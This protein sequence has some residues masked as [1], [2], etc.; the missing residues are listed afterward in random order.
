M[1]R[2]G[3]DPSQPG[4]ILQ[5][6]AGVT[7]PLTAGTAFNRLV[8]AR[9]RILTQLAARLQRAGYAPGPIRDVAHGYRM[10]IVTDPEGHRLELV[11]SGQPPAGVVTM[12][13]A[14][15]R[16]IAMASLLPLAAVASRAAGA[17][18]RPA[19]PRPVVPATTPLNRLLHRLRPQAATILPRSRSARSRGARSLAYTEPAN[20]PA[21]HCGGCA[22]FV[23]RRQARRLPTAAAP[24]SCWATPR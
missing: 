19:P 3:S 10:M 20:D 12:D 24:A 7:A 14:R 9:F 16:F 11:Q 15:R 21:R 23:A 8:L 22:F 18:P 17:K 2:F 5:T 6:V 1:M 4:I 13:H